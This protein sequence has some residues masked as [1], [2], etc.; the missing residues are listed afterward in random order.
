MLAAA[1]LPIAHRAWSCEEIRD[2]LN[3]WIDVHARPPTEADWARSG[4]QPAH[5]APSSVHVLFGSWNA[6]LLAGGV[7]PRHRVWSR[8][9][10]LA[11]CAAVQARAGRAI[12]VMDFDDPANGLPSIK[13]LRRKIGDITRLRLELEGAQGARRPSRFARPA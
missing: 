3:A 6:M 1:E 8:E 5:P 7:Q 13:T 4:A 2:A 12:A 10:V 11:A 9:E